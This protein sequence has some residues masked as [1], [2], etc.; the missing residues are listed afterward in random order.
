M[1]GMDR[2]RK[3]QIPDLISAE[4]MGRRFSMALKMRGLSQTA[5]INRLRKAFQ[6]TRIGRAEMS[7]LCRGYKMPRLGRLLTI[8]LAL[9]LDLR[10]LF[11]EAFDE[12]SRLVTPG[13]HPEAFRS[14]LR[15]S[16]LVRLQ[17][18]HPT[19]AAGHRS[20]PSS[21]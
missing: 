10:V 12:K 19:T 2:T 20:P 14:G 6:D 21:A 18:S 4:E 11:R 5:A 16:I 15:S 3:K 7:S 8:A 17:E 13:T 9:G 1:S